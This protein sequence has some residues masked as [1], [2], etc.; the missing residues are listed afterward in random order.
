MASNT[1]EEYVARKMWIDQQL[2]K[3]EIYTSIIDEHIEEIYNKIKTNPGIQHAIILYMSTPALERRIKNQQEASLSI[4]Y[5]VIK[6]NSDIYKNS[7][8]MRVVY[9]N[10]NYICISIATYL[11]L[12]AMG[13]KH[14]SSIIHSV[15]SIKLDDYIRTFKEKSKKISEYNK[16][17]PTVIKKCFQC[18]AV[19]NKLKTCTGCKSAYYCNQEC[20]ILHWKL[21]KIHC[22]KK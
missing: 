19:T 7:P 4:E 12:S 17:K 11:P 9:D 13:S 5:D 22:Q 16:E 3:T 14:D 8:S 1:T 2:S 20:Q 15:T 18:S 21:H 6:K 10:P